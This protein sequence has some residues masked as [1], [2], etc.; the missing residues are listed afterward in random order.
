MKKYLFLLFMLVV[1]IL[2]LIRNNTKNVANFNNLSNN[3][4]TINID[5]YFENGINS[6]K[7]VDE[8]K[9]YNYEYLIKNINI[10]NNSI[11]LNCKLIEKCINNIYDMNDDDF[12]NK[13]IANGFRIEKLTIITDKNHIINYLK[14]KDYLYRIY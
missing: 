9:N 2:L 13:Y 7:L 11:N 8:F 14:N 5:I 4:S 1:Y 10:G 6:K 3:N 12:Y